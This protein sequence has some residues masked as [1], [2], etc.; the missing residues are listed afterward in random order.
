[1]KDVSGDCRA[2]PRLETSEA[3][4]TLGIH[5]GPDG[6]QLA[7]YNHLLDTTKSSANKLRTSFLKEPEAN[8]ALKTTIL[9]KLEYPLPA[10]SLT[11][12]QCGAIMRPVLLAALPKAKY[13][14]NFP[15]SP[16][17][18]PGSHQGCELHNLY[19]TQVVEHFNIALRHSPYDTMT[20][21]LL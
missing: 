8:A 20:G 14:H 7:A 4:A 9:K 15:R 12:A 3:F 16:L 1:V 18:G 13:N 6:S 10:L 17:Y 5:L 11:E 2:I 19:T 21:E